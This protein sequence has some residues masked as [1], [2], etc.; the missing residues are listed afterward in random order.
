MCVEVQHST[1]VAPVQGHRDMQGQ[2]TFLAIPGIFDGANQLYIK[3]IKL[4]LQGITK[5]VTSL[6]NF[7]SSI[8]I[9]FV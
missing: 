1:I 3:F 7:Q 4:T 6:C 5:W 9:H 8:D 2:P